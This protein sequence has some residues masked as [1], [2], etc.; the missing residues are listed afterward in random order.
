M[1]VHFRKIGRRQYAVLAE[2]DGAPALIAH[3][4][5]GYDEYLPHDLLHFVAEAEWGIDG[6]VFGQLA[7]G[8]DPG[9]FL[10]T[11]PMLVPQW[12]LRSSQQL[13]TRRAVIAPKW[14]ADPTSDTTARRGRRWTIGVAAQD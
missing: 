2:P 12:C 13:R 3:P 8:G 5:P 9:I 11:D 10:P 7:A 1:L 14:C 4:A 6:A